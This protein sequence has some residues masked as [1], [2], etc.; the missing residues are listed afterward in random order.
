MSKV[1]F[2]LETTGRSDSAR[3]LQFGFTV[4]NS[5]IS[6]VINV[7]TNLTDY[8]PSA[9][10]MHRRNMGEILNRSLAGEYINEKEGLRQFVK[11]LQEY[12]TDTLGGYNVSNFDME[13]LTGRLRK[14]GLLEE[15]DFVSNLK[16][17]DTIDDTKNFLDVVL[18]DYE[19]VAFPSYGSDVTRR[20]GF[21]TLENL[22][23]GFN[24][25]YDAHNA[26]ADA[27]TANLVNEK[28]RHYQGDFDVVEWYRGVVES[29]RVNLSKDQRFVSQLDKIIRIKEGLSEERLAEITEEVR[30][31]NFSTPSPQKSAKADLGDIEWET[32]KEDVSNSFRQVK[33]KFE[34]FSPTTQR[35]LAYV[36]LGAAALFVYN[37]SKDQPKAIRQEYPD[38]YEEF[39]AMS[40]HDAYGF[41]GG[42]KQAFYSN[43]APSFGKCSTSKIRDQMSRNPCLPF[44]KTNL[45]GNYQVNSSRSLPRN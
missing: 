14:F 16:V 5:E 15:L 32:F 4:D 18:K 26:G 34:K 8:E 2:D 19:E 23:R 40:P 41:P 12:N 6:E 20:K 43:I 36:G 33:E 29:N 35:N 27:V 28:M 44:P 42:R 31:I 30:E 7:N 10:D 3:I 13:I 11:K 37:M 45:G 39:E 24:I 22:A 38:A 1:Y 25:S 9:L 21:R 17:L